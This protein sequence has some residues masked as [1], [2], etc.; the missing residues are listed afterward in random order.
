MAVGSPELALEN[1]DAMTSE[2]L[3]SELAKAKTE[4]FNLRFQHATGQLE[5][6]GRILAV[7]KDIAR[8]ETFLRERELG[9]RTEPGALEPVESSDSTPKSKKS[10]NKSPA[11]PKR[12]DS[13]G[14]SSAPA[15]AAA[16]HDSKGDSRGDSA[17]SKT[18]AGRKK[19]SQSTESTESTRKNLPILER[20]KKSVR[21]TS[22]PESPKIAASKGT[23]GQSK[24]KFTR[25]K[26]G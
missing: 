7:R 20:L 16:A 22:T 10:P 6:H 21:K 13:S 18:K 26:K 19:S 4:M 5:S 23:G 3:L 17:K 8:I 1:L 11:A 12:P 14:D 2:N 24:S 25:Q 9:I 15:K